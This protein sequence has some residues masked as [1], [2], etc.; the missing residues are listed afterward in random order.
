MQT[1]PLVIEHPCR[2]ELNLIPAGPCI[3]GFDWSRVPSAGPWDVGIRDGIGALPARRIVM[4]E[5]LIGKYPV[6][7][8]QFRAFLKATRRKEQF[9]GYGRVPELW[10]SSTLECRGRDMDRKPVVGI[11]LADAAAFCD[12]LRRETGLPFTLPSDLQWEKA[13]RGEDGRPY[14]WGHEEPDSSRCTLPMGNP[15]EMSPVDAHPAG[16]SAYGVMDMAGNAFEMCFSE[17]GVYD[18]YWHSSGDGIRTVTLRGSWSSGP[19]NAL[20]AYSRTLGGA[21]KWG[22]GSYADHW[23]GFRVA[24]AIDGEPRIDEAPQPLA[25]NKSDRG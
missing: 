12:W 2:L 13:A 11:S 9:W 20:L 24:T 4:P 17:F 16:A 22:E 23:V 3:V 18:P 15:F 7:N 6:T 8:E 5:Y 1:V 19:R 10:D 14:P 21:A 25:E